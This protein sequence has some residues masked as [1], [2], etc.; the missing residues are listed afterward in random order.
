MRAYRVD[1]VD[2]ET[3]LA[4]HA[5][6]AMAAFKA[7]QKALGAEVTLRG[8]AGKW[9]R[10]VELNDKPPTRLHPGVFEFRIVGRKG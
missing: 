3:V 8:G 1:E 5:V 7:A 10:V 2:G 6:A 4:S 9:I